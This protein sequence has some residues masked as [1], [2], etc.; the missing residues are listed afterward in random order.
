ML[1][2]PAHQSR[3]AE[4]IRTVVLGKLGGHR[5]HHA[6]LIRHLADVREQVTHIQP[7]LTV[8]FEIPRRLQRLADVVK[9]RRVDLRGERL[10]VVLLET[11]LV[12]ERIDLRHTAVHVEKMTLL[13]LAS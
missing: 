6:Q 11:R 5:A 3:C 7:G 13:A 4:K 8:L 9:L 2:G 1:G 12:I 10:A